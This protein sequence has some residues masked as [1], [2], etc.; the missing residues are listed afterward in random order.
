MGEYT[1][2]PKDYQFPV[3]SDFKDCVILAIVLQ[4]ALSILGNI[5]YYLIIPCSK[6]KGD[7]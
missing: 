2:A 3:I 1:H 7:L 5:F 6:G 4:I